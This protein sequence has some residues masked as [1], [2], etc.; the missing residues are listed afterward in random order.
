MRSTFGRI[1]TAIPRAT[2]G[3]D[4]VSA[5]AYET[6]FHEFAARERLFLNEL[7]VNNE[8]VNLPS[9]KDP[10]S[11]LYFSTGFSAHNNVDVGIIETIFLP[12]LATRRSPRIRSW[13]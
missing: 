9:E 6:G 2:G 4:I 8:S 3:L 11:T 7:P 12:A 1:E 5:D 10:I 13:V